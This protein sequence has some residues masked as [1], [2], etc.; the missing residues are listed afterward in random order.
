MRNYLE[1]MKIRVT[2]GVSINTDIQIEPDDSTP[3][4]P[5]IFIS[6]LENAFK[7]G[8]SP[9]GSGNISVELSQVD[10][11]VTCCIKN[12]NYPKRD[13]DKSGSGIGLEQVSKRLELMYPD[14]YQWERGTTDDKS[15]YYSKI[16]IDTQ[17][18]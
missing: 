5:L 11:V 18:G 4:A 1:L 13:N 9:S 10:G 3:I 7:H 14:R 12:S 2:S 17:L 16:I 15:I 6:L 8:I